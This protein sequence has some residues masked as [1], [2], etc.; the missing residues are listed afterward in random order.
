MFFV[1]NYF[2]YRNLDSDCVCVWICERSRKT[3]SLSN[4][5]LSRERT[6]EL[7]F[8]YHI[9]GYKFEKNPNN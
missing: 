8:F 1:E 7:L 5:F 4:V 6:H 2:Y 3:Y 9:D